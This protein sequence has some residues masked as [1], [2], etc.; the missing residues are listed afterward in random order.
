M[1]EDILEQLVD[2]YLQ[3]FGYFTRHNIKFRPAEGCDGHDKQQDSVSSDIDVIGIN[4]HLQGPA[5]VMVVSCKSWQG[6]FRPGYWITA[7]EQN[8]KVNGRDAW[9]AFRE[10]SNEK[11]SQAFV[12][13]VREISGARDFTYVTAVTVLKGDKAVWE[14]NPRFL[15]LLENNR[16]QLLTLEDMLSHLYPTIT[17]TQASSTIGRVLQLMKASGWVYRSVAE[18]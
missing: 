14:N 15:Q 12:R 10:V 9:R 6:G 3:H 4:P 8:K 17:T 11:W 5:R 13:R 18:R 1:K 2:E 7:I 16:I